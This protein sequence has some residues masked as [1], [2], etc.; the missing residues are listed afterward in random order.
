M[1]LE[2]F[3]YDIELKHVPGK[4]LY[5]A[6]AL[7]HSPS[8]TE[9]KTDLLNEGAAVVYTILTAT[10]EKTKELKEASLKDPDI[11]MLKEYVK[12]GF[13]SKFDKMPLNVRK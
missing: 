11:S 12:K 5:V 9:F 6:D 1:A 7:S 10:E 4:Q 2:L 13:S 8:N 3:R